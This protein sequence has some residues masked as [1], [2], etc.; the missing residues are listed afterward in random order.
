M[1]VSSYLFKLS[2]NLSARIN[3][4]DGLQPEDNQRDH[5]QVHHKEP[6]PDQMRAQL[7]RHQQNYA[8]S[9]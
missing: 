8:T 7:Q 6:P 5:G 4:N 2:G 3:K 9:I 1:V